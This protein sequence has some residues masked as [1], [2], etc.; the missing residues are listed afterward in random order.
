MYIIFIYIIMNVLNMSAH[1]ART[2]THMHPLV[3][4]YEHRVAVAPLRI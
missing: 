3:C 1:I 2:H 4:A